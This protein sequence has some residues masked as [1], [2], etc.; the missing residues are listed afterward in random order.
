M[1][2]FLYTNELTVG[3]DADPIATF[4]VADYF[5]VNCLRQESLASFEKNLQTLI[6]A[7]FWR[8][9]RKQ[10]LKLQGPE[11]EG[12]DPEGVL[13]RVTARNCQAVLNDSGIWDDIVQVSPGFADKVLRACFPKPQRACSM[14]LKRSASNAFNDAHRRSQGGGRYAGDR[15]A[16]D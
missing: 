2:K 11:W 15:F 8:N 6:D 3:Q 5:Q 4:A 14:P 1:L 7:K 12:R 9:Y 13:V 16:K 10:A